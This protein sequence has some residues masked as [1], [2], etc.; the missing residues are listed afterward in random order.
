M[1]NTGNVTLS[2]LVVTDDRGVA[3]TC[4]QASLAPGGEMVCTASG[5]AAAG[6]Y[7]NIGSVAGVDPFGTPVSDTD[8]S[9]YTGAV[10]GIDIEKATNGSDADHPP[11]PFLPVGG[12]VTWTYVVRNEGSVFLTGVTVT[13]DRG[14]AV[15]CPGN[16]LAIGASMTCT[17]AGIAAGGPYENTATVTASAGAV[18]VQD[19]DASHYFGEAASVDIEKL[20]NGVDADVPTGPMVGVGGPVGWTYAVTNTGNVPLRWSV[21]DN[22]IAGLTCPQPPL[23]LPG[24]SF[25]CHAGGS[26]TIGQHT[27]IGTVQGVTPSGQVVADNDPANYFGVQGGIELKKFTNGDDADVAPGPFISVGAPITWTYDVANTGNGVLTSVVVRDLDGV[28]VTCPSST[29][30]VGA[31]MTCTGAG[32]AQPGQYTNI[33]TVVGFTA[34]GRRAFDFD[35]SNYYGAVGDILVEKSTNGND[36]DAAPGP[37]VRVGDPVTW[38]YT[39]YNTGNTALTGIAVTDDR[40]VAVSCP[41]ATLAAGAQ[42]ECTASGTATLGQYEN[43]GAAV[44]TDPAGNRVFDADRSHYFGVVSGIDVEKYTNG[45]DADTPTGPVVT[46]GGAVNWTY[47][48]RNTGNI[49]IQQVTLVDDGGVAPDLVGGGDEQ[50]DPN[51]TWTYAAAGIATAGQ[52][53]STATVSGLDMLEDPVSDSDPSHHLAPLPVFPQPQPPLPQPPPPAPGGGEVKPIVIVTK[54]SSHSR[55]RAGTTVRFT[56]R[57]RNAGS[58]TARSVRVCDRLPSGLAFASARGARIV[59]RSACF[60]AGTMRV[61]Q[62]RT[63][64]VSA[65]ADATSRPRRIC[66]VAVRTASGLSARRVRECVRI[67]PTFEPRPGGVTG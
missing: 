11:G 26:A 61:R 34:A 16:T 10:P 33:A 25:T 59:G 38:T 44:G 20:V 3:V 37:A 21:S 46:A 60:N 41:S 40:G 65:R 27:N 54:R 53:G 4:P 63:F 32:T 9:H 14:V 47:V 24:S 5:A 52:Y 12:A 13:D 23:I 29:L 36:A 64:V 30:A 51:E 8:P 56:L 62:A 55:V 28:S 15:S 18:T 17:G 7:V 50:L 31:S 57:V 48:V 6:A 42:M 49:P 35:P 19:S 22:L 67:L 58:V 45:E 43:T 1:T 2:S 66:N 39:V